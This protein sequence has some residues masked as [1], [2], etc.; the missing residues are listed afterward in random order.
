MGMTYHSINGRKHL[1][2]HEL[3]EKY[4]M[5]NLHTQP[6]N[7]QA[8]CGFSESSTDI[9]PTGPIVRVSPDEVY[10]RSPTGAATIHQI[11]RPFLKGQFYQDFTPGVESIFNTRD[12][13]FHRRHRKLLS[14]PL[15]ESQLQTVYLPRI[16]AHF[17]LAFSKMHD[18]I[19]RDGVMD[20]N[21]W[22]LYLA[23][24]II[25]ELAF[26]DSFHM[27]EKDEVNQYI[28]DLKGIP[29]VLALRFALGKIIARPW[30]RY[31]PGFKQARDQFDR[32]L[33][34]ADESLDRHKRLVKEARETGVEVVPTLM[35][36][37][38]KGLDSGM[39]EK[40]QTL[41]HNELRDDAG[42]FIVAGSDTTSNTLTYLV[43][44]VLRHPEIHRKLVEEVGALAEGFTQND[45]K[46]LKFM[47]MVIQ[48][49]LRLYSAAP[50]AL[51]RVVPKGGAEIDGLWLPEDTTVTTMAYTLHRDESVYRDAGKFDPWRW[52]NPTKAMKDAW[53]PW[54][55]GTR[56]KFRPSLV[57]V[58]SC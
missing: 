25:G 8:L 6:R 13:E 15:S 11:K 7:F 41:E 43:W 12:P 37:M 46:E 49:T 2:A 54:G 45:L 38:Y 16:N 5:H 34:Y 48:E 24:D 39:D 20:I 26:G 9:F 1:W 21:K 52:N 51:P 36:K 35:Q 40:G 42:V 27:L 23:T 28:L 3:H 17:D 57:I 47:N 30:A 50:N 31:L 58:Y 10:V 18:D 19:A 56:S 22:W 29:I 44:A 55:G 14:F 4:G 33:A 32:N 53:M